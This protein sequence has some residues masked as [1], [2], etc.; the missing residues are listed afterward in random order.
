MHGHPVGLLALGCPPSVECSTIHEFT[1]YLQGKYP[2]LALAQIDFPDREGM[3]L[4]VEDL[5]R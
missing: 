3:E 5:R 4:G 2:G 1:S